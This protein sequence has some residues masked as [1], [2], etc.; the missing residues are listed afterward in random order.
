MITELPR[1][2]EQL[3]RSEIVERVRSD[4]RS[5]ERY[6]FLGVDRS[7]ALQAIG[8]GQATFDEPW[9]SL[10]PGDRALLYAYFNQPG[11]LEELTA[12][13]RMLFASGP[14]DREPNIR[15][16][17]DDDRTVRDPIQRLSP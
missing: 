4:T 7:T 12:A 3:R 15:R 6:P 2:L 9:G 17:I 11:H 13:F 8:W 16:N 10:S 1:W 14:P 5:S